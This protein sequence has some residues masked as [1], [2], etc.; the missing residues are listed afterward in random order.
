MRAKYVLLFSALVAAGPSPV[1]AQSPSSD[2][3][4]VV[5]GQKM[6]SFKVHGKL[7]KENGVQT[8][9]FRIVKATGDTDLDSL[10]LQASN[11]CGKQVLLGLGK[12]NIGNWSKFNRQ[13][14]EC[15]SARAPG[16]VKDL[17]DRRAA[18]GAR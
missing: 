2:D 17:H 8:V 6:K 15:V 12:V 10:L 5:L 3:Q 4:I 1:A 7:N 9:S 11:D 14:N 13:W 18:E 16:L